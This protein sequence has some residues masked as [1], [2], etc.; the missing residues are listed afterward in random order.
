VETLVPAWLD[1]AAAPIR[2]GVHVNGAFGLALLHESAWES[3]KGT[4]NVMPPP[5]NHGTGD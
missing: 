1:R 5:I 3:V 2:H 4:N